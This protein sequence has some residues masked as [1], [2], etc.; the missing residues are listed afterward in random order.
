M[1]GLSTWYLGPSSTE[2]RATDFPKSGLPVG[3]SVKTS[4]VG[5]LLGSLT[6]SRGVPVETKRRCARI[7][8][9][10]H[11]MTDTL[12]VSVA[13]PSGDSRKCH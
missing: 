1:E 7:I 12:H 6:T 4:G 2:G 13:C 10:C 5:A 8:I 9:S 11:Q 3:V